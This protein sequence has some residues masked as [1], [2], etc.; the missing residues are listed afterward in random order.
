[1]E[2]LS[3]ILPFVKPN[4]ASLAVSEFFKR[5]YT[6]SLPAPYTPYIAPPQGI[7][8]I[9][10]M[11]ASAKQT[12]NWII[13]DL[14][15]EGDQLI[16]GGAP[17]AGK[18][19][20]AL[21]LALSV[22]SGGKFLEWRA[23]ERRRVLYINLEIKER[24]MGVR[25]LK[26]AGGEE[27]IQKYSNLYCMNIQT[28]IDI[29]DSEQS[30]TLTHLIE[31]LDVDLVVWDVL[32]RMHSKDEMTI[33]MLHVMQE[34]RRV[35]AGRAHVVVH[36]ARKP[37]SDSTA[38]QTAH[39]IRGSSSIFGEC[40]GVFVITA[41]SGQGA[42]FALTA[43]LRAGR[44]PDLML[45]DR[46]EHTLRFVDPVEQEAAELGIKLGEVFQEQTVIETNAELMS[47][48]MAV[49]GV[50]ERQAH[51]YA[52]KAVELGYLRTVKNGRAT[53]YHLL[54]LALKMI[55][56]AKSRNYA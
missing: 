30:S 21:Q 26:M 10:A 44:A 33:E 16:I 3:K 28:R 40:D 50:E 24:V 25:I 17:K 32:A 19:L 4:S 55:R 42:R 11:L 8:G 22:A 1:M 12:P 20:L 39:D 5:H 34:I 54:P 37:P 38:P 41:R 56:N 36:H 48:L 6:P 49:F 51:R 29:M 53:E 35:S 2:K 47:R 45:L 43:Q 14:L 23:P 15:E 27:Q 7:K 31:D 13:Q 9:G 46:D 18:S 52:K